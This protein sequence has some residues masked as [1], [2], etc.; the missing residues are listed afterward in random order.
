MAQ[1]NP[2]RANPLE[3]EAIVLIDEIELHLHPSWQQRILE[4]LMRTF[5]NTQFIVSTH[6]PQILTTVKPHQIVGL[7]W[8]DNCIVAHQANDATFGAKAGEVLSTVMGVDERPSRIEFVKVLGKYTSL[9]SDGQGE[10]EEAANLRKKLEE[11][12]HRDPAL[13]RADIEIRRQRI[14]KKMSA[15]E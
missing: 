6:S 3:A 14:M 7:H 2:H 9:V 12:S 10:F 8:E 4:D 11:L 1:G 5:P 13:D 15:P